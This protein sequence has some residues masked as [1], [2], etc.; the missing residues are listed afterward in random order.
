[1]IEIVLAMPVTN[2]PKAIKRAVMPQASSIL[3][4]FYLV[5]K[6]ALGPFAGLQAEVNIL[7]LPTGVVKGTSLVAETVTE[8][9]S[10]G[11]EFT[12]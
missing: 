11:E 6:L 3:F 9:R 4:S 1:M 2:A 5:V 7:P 12:Y 8:G 10:F